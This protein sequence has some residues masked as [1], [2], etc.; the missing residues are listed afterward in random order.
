LLAL[1]VSTL[2]IYGAISFAVVQRRRTIGILRALGATRRDVLVIVLTEATVLGVVGAGLG[3]LLGVGIG[4]GLVQLV[5]RTINDLYF[6]VAVNETILPAR[7]V[8][9]ALLAGLGAALAGAG[10]PPGGQSTSPPQCRNWD[11]GAPCSK[12]AR[13]RCLASCS[14]PVAPLRW[15]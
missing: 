13:S 14:T 4:R 10:A 7:S 3:L 12:H 9:K 2:L 11:F 6:V 8:V 5:S 1:L 15:L